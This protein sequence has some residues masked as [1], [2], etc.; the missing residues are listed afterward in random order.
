[1]IQSFSPAESREVLHRL[2]ELFEIA[3]VNRAVIEEA[4]QSKI[5]DFDDAVLA[6]AGGL[7]GVD[8][9]ITRNTKDF[10][11]AT[12]KALDPIEFLSSLKSG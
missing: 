5:T 1:M 10:Q 3:P 8:A 11:P 7:V 2:L 9:I 4:L 6:H 12:I